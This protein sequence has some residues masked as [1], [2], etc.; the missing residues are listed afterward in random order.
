MPKKD[1]REEAGNETGVSSTH[2]FLA[3][4]TPRARFSTTRVNP[5]TKGGY[6]QALLSRLSS[7]WMATLR[8]PTIKLICRH[9][10]PQ[11]SL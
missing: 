11:H 4:E 3:H 1:G 6:I 5:I 10:R 7:W 9:Q 2:S 8:E